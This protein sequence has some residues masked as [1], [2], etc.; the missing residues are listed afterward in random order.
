MRCFSGFIFLFLFWFFSGMGLWPFLSLSQP[1]LL[2][3]YLCGGGS[4]REYIMSTLCLLLCF[5]FFSFSALFFNFLVFQLFFN[6]L[7]FLFSFVFLFISLF[8][9]L[10]ICFFFL[11]FASF[12]PPFLKKVTIIR[13]IIY[14]IT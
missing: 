7:V 3:S 14:E 6:F 11:F 8:F 13:N 2:L 5:L 12:H 1:S 9:T 4:R 10:F